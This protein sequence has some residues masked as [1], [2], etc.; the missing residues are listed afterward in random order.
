[1]P[2]IDEANKAVATARHHLD[3]AAKALQVFL[4]E[5]DDGKPNEWEVEISTTQ[6]GTTPDVIYLVRKGSTLDLKVSKTTVET[7]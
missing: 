7:L 2:T 4:K 1:M 6:G 5:G 3:E